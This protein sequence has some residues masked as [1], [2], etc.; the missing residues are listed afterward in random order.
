MNEKLFDI[1]LFAKT[2]TLTKKADDYSNWEDEVK[3]PALAG[4]DDI[5]NQGG[6]GKDTIRSE[7]S[8]CSLY[9]GAGNDYI[10]NEGQA[11][12]TDSLVADSNVTIKGGAGNDEIY[13][14]ASKF[15]GGN[16]SLQ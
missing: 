13:N 11:D 2:V 7:A 4:N 6:K 1:Q 15:F 9:G 10:N 14:S 8:F 3:I 5:R 12:Y 16:F